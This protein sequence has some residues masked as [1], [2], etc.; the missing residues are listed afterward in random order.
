[1][2]D[3]ISAIQATVAKEIQS[4]AVKTPLP[5]DGNDVLRFEQA[6]G[7]LRPEKNEAVLSLKPQFTVNP[8]SSDMTSQMAAKMKEVDGTYKSIVDRMMN[9]KRFSDFKV[10]NGLKP[11]S[12][13]GHVSNIS[14][15]ST[16]VPF[17]KDGKLNIEAF[18]NQLKSFEDHNA[19]LYKA[20]AEFMRESSTWQLSTHFWLSKLKIITSTVSS[21]SNGVK[22][23]FRGQ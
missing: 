13:T 10:E 8:V 22:M 23:L 7:N 1:M 4:Q 12:D 9:W 21:A 2:V 17:I 16:E 20:G 15:V 11:A 6:M 14:K 3:G 19:K 18:G 5:A